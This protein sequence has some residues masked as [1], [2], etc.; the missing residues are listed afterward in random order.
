MNKIYQDLIIVDRHYRDKKLVIP[1][2]SHIIT[3]NFYT[4]YV[5][6]Q[7]FD[8]GVFKETNIDYYELTSNKLVID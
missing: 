1:R 8:N 3:I 7:Y 5:R 6:V 4:D 2:C